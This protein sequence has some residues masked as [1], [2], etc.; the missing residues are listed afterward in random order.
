[1]AEKD[2]KQVLSV[3]EGIPVTD[4]F[5]VRN[6]IIQATLNM[7][8]DCAV[9]LAERV[10]MY[11]RDSFA[12]AY[13]EEL[14]EL[15][16]H[17]LKGGEIKA[18]MDVAREI[19][20]VGTE[21]ISQSRFRNV[22]GRIDEWQYLKAVEGF[23]P[24]FCKFAGMKGLK[25]FRDLLIK[26]IR[27]DKGGE[28]ESREDYLYSQKR[29]EVDEHPDMDVRRALAKGLRE[30]CKGLIEAD[31]RVEKE[32]L[33][34]LQSQ[35]SYYVFDRIEM[36]LL[37]FFPEGQ[38]E[39]IKNILS[40]REYYDNHSIQTEY[41]EL[42]KRQ[43][44][45][46]GTE[47]QN[48]YLEYVGERPDVN[49]EI[50]KWERFSGK[51]ITKDDVLKHWRIEKLRMLEG[52][53]NV[54]PEQWQQ[55]Y[56]KLV[57]EFGETQR[58]GKETVSE[59]WEGGYGSP[60]LAEELEKKTVEEIIEYLRIWEAPDGWQWGKVCQEG[61]A[62]EVAKVIEKRF[63]EFC[64]NAVRLI[65]LEATYVRRFLRLVETKCSEGVVI[66]WEGILELCKWVANQSLEM[67]LLTEGKDNDWSGAQD[68]VVGLIKLGVT[69]DKG[70]FPFEYRQLVWECIEPITRSPNPTPEREK[71][72]REDNAN[73]EPIQFAINSTRGRA[74]E[75]I[76]EYGWWV[77]NNLSEGNV[78]LDNFEGIE[79]VRSVLE[80]H[81]DVEKEPLLAIRA[82]YG[83][84]FPQL[85]VLGKKWAEEKTDII[86]PST[87][88]DMNDFM[89]AAWDSYIKFSKVYDNVFQLLRDKYSWAIDRM[90]KQGERKDEYED[91]DRRLARHL[92]IMYTRGVLSPADKLWA[93]FWE[94]A[95]DRIRKEAIEFI[96]RILRD[97]SNS[98][99]T[100]II[101]RFCDL[102]EDRLKKIEGIDEKEQSGE[103]FRA[104]GW[105]FECEVIEEEWLLE[106]L[107]RV[108]ILTKGRIDWDH[109]V[110]ERLNKMFEKHPK[111][112]LLVLR[113]MCD[114][115]Y[116]GWSM[117]RNKEV[118]E[119]VL[120]KALKSENSKVKTCADEFVN[121]LGAMG[122]QHFRELAD[123]G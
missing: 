32:V 51:K 35:P 105:W 78:I 66:S 70:R 57:E 31:R 107:E 46:I 96:G 77:K 80:E 6:D 3:I 100:D 98:F 110:A 114:G 13:V 38:D 25:L 41:H 120:R 103:E 58:L 121:H 59:S 118:Y 69:R 87:N 113:K 33:E 109:K 92:V 7:P 22:K 101:K 30:L 18:G 116:E 82:I 36:F 60:I 2:P 106:K 67:L 10:K 48:C 11:M 84:W 14:C 12:Q 44:G 21:E 89:C 72:S 39:R 8:A 49:E 75:G 65:D 28:D 9:Q 20:G 34:Q 115:Y 43:F 50:T 119:N 62:D 5:F 108:L 54:L 63:E 16:V 95:P 42:L 56:D 90:K 64:D 104:F 74:L 27:L 68:A 15:V 4:N 91:V 83:Q 73:F 86:F 76:V 88:K 61:L 23:V 123:M 112:V 40:D 47:A 29:I 81:L 79:D 24:V 97:R 102:F 93:K 117:I 111:K 94:D 19:L 55:E 1:M 45:N 85:T 37:R 17:L 71:Q 122:Y 52:L 26:A 53:S 99:E